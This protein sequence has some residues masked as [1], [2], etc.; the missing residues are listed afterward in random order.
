MKNKT[1]K[2]IHKGNVILRNNMLHLDSSKQQIIEKNWSSEIKKNP[3]IFNGQVLVFINQN[4]NINDIIIDVG[5]T[6]YKNVLASR[7]IPEL[8][9]K[10]VGVSA[11]TIIDDLGEKFVL[12]STRSKNNT[13]YP[14]FIELVPSGHIDKS[15]LQKNNS[16]DYTQKIKEEFFEETGCN[17]SCINKVH[18]LMFNL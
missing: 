1:Y 4:K 17:Q 6:E 5:F 9:I 7:K 13:E 14:G 16:I 15:A 8:N 18:R 11:I 10:P 3:K 2:I 12:F